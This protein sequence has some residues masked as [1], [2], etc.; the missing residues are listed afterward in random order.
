MDASIYHHLGDQFKWRHPDFPLL[1]NLHKLLWMDIE[2]SPSQLRDTICPVFLGSSTVF[3]QVD[4]PETPHLG[5]V[6]AEFGSD[7]Q[8]TSN[9]SFWCWLQRLYSET[10][11]NDQA[12]FPIWSSHCFKLRCVRAGG[13]HDQSNRITSSAKKQS[14]AP[15]TTN[16]D[17]SHH[18]VTSRNSFR[19]S[20]ECDVD[21]PATLKTAANQEHPK[22]PS[23]CHHTAQGQLKE[24]GNEISQSPKV[25]VP[26]TTTGFL[27]PSPDGLELWLIVV[28][29]CISVFKGCL[30]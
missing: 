10:L 29:F 27:C 15:E 25:P 1:N 30:F 6:Q 19:H 9:G 16:L 3:P 21:I 5:G 24:H 11:L 18:Q 7:A 22:G 20:C 26:D 23:V 8:T 28:N 2:V 17:T 13:H 12:P 14:W 4:S